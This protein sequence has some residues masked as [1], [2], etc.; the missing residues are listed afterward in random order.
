MR[1]PHGGYV[2]EGVVELEDRKL[3][4]GSFIPAQSNVA[5]PEGNAA[6]FKF[7]SPQGL[8]SRIHKISHLYKADAQHH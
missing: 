3:D 1:L 7:E 5:S 2:F 8:K 6:I 4:K